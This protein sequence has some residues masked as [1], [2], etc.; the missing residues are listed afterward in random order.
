MPAIAGPEA[1]KIKSSP[2]LPGNETPCYVRFQ[3]LTERGFVEFEFGA[4]S[5]DLMVDLILP[6]AAY[7][8][9]CK[10]N[11]VIQ[12][13]REQERAID[14]ERAKWRYGSPGISE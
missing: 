14:H 13:T 11:R 6:V 10:A 2:L 8:E 9:F 3:R 12:L 1:M 5:C 7:R 4:G